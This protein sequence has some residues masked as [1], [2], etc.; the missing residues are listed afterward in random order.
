[1]FRTMNNELP[2]RLGIFVVSD[3]EKP[4]ETQKGGYLV[5]NLGVGVGIL[6]LIGQ[7]GDR[8]IN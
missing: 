6:R 5:G 7:S 4:T 2:V 1:M 8:H 3:N